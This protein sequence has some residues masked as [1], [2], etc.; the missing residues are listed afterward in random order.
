M[1][2]TTLK[3]YKPVE[4]AAKEEPVRRAK[5]I[6]NKG[7]SRKQFLFWGGGA[8]AAIYTLGR[9]AYA[10]THGSKNPVIRPPGAMKEKEFKAACARCGNCMKVC[11]TNGLQPVML[12]SGFDG[13]WTPKIDK[14]AGYCEYNCNACGQVCPTQAIKALPLEEKM[15][16]KIGVAEIVKDVCVPWKDGIECLVCEEHCPIPEKAIK[17]VKEIING[18]EIDVPVINQDL[19]IGCAVCENKCPVEGKARG[20]TVNPV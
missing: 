13:I 5:Q 16:Q 14:I 2:C 15:Q 4:A 17:F 7:I 3:C 9:K 10:V 18:K 12:E 11:I 6:E 20:I 1:D 8:V 19:C